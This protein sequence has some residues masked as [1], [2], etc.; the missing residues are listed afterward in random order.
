MKRGRSG[1]PPRRRRGIARPR[2]RGAGE[3]GEEA[4][5]EGE[6]ADGSTTPALEDILATA[7]SRCLI[8]QCHG[9]RHR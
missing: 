4:G 2:R 9:S 7:G 5:Q 8:G 6:D 1:G 3:V